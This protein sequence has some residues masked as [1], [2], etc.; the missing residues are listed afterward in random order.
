[1]FAMDALQAIQLA[2]SNL[3]KA[4]A[5]FDKLCISSILV[6]GILRIIFGMLVTIYCP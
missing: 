6:L 2:L 4:R 5:A 1:M 3:D